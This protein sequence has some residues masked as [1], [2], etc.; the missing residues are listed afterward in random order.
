ML[1]PV[2]YQCP[3]KNNFELVLEIWNRISSDETDKKTDWF[4]KAVD[5]LLVN[6]T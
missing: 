5:V 6:S 2:L 4:C 1:W 3:S